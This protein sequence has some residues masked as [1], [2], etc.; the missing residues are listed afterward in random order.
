MGDIE[1]KTKSRDESDKVLNDVTAKKSKVEK[2]I[3]D[4]QMD[5]N[6]TGKEIQVNFFLIL[7]P[8]TLLERVGC[9][10]FESE[11]PKYN[12]NLFMG[13]IVL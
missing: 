9:F 5:L 2:T 3:K 10:F 6:R 12:F 4:L 13:V 1:L 11:F 7:G 8:T